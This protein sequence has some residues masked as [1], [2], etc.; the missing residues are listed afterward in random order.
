MSRPLAVLIGPPGAGKTTIAQALAERLDVAVRDTDED[1][2]AVAGRSVA[3]IFVQDG[4][5]HFRELEHTAVSTALAEHE[6]V[7]A[8]GGGAVLDPRTQE[9]LRGHTVVFLDVRIA[10]AAPRIGLNR[11]RPL[12]IGNPRAQWTMMMDHRRPIYTELATHRIA[13][14]GL[15][16]EEVTEAVLTAL[17]R[18]G[19][20][21]AEHTGTG[22]STQSAGSPSRATS[23][24]EESMAG[25]PAGAPSGDE[26]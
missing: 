13:T 12:L 10:D 21:P 7:L 4:E 22:R 15:T 11:D 14:D 25:Q 6:G 16:P 20:D 2:V 1:V 17:G 8:L 3:D 19:Q 26:S 9:E 18:S 5:P 24:A 23:A